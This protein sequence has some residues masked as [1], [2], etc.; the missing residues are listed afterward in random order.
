MFDDICWMLNGNMLCEVG[1]LM[2]RVGKDREAQALKRAGA[3]AMDITGQPMPG[4][5]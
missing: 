2:F 3:S 4:F 5:L 1:R